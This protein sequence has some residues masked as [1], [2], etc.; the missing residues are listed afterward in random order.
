MQLKKIVVKLK[1]FIKK[2]AFNKNSTLLCI[3]TNYFS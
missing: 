1:N 2:F 3:V